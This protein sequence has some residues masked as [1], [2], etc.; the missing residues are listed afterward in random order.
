MKKLIA[1]CISG[2]LL[3]SLSSPVQASDAST[4]YISEIAVMPNGIVLFNHSGTRT[5]T[6]SCQ[7]ASLQTRWAFDAKTATGQAKLATLLAAKGMGKPIRVLGTGTCA[8]WN[9]TESLNYF[10]IEG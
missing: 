1:L 9:D 4:G 10:V 3:S 8:D 7:G 2:L 5:A 6:P